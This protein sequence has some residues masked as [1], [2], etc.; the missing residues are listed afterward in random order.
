MKILL[1]AAL[2]F[3]IVAEEA[4]MG[5]YHD[6]TDISGNS[7]LQK[8]ATVASQAF[9]AG[10]SSGTTYAFASSA[11][12]YDPT[13][14]K[15]DIVSAKQ[16]VVAGMNYNIALRFTTTDEPQQCVGGF[17][18]TVYDHF[19]DLNVTNWGEELTCD[20]L[21]TEQQQQEELV[22]RN[23][24]PNDD[25]FGSEITSIKISNFCYIQQGDGFACTD[26]LC[27]GDEDCSGNYLGC[28]SSQTCHD[29]GACCTK[30]DG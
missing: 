4:L 25:M 16:Q 9:L 21:V 17:R 19:G 11:K 5:G 30:V 3:T 28:S 29:K 2:C 7:F 24:E 13:H 23:A 12:T 14:L 22:K 1:V 20:Q 6:I 10:S 18:V 8:A 27:T 26:T 15:Y